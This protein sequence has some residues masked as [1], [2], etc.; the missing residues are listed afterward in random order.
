MRRSATDPEK[1]TQAGEVDEI[2]QNMLTTFR[3]WKVAN[4]VRNALIILI[5]L[6]VL[7]CFIPTDVGGHPRQ[8]F[9]KR[10]IEILTSTL[11]SF[12][13]DTGRFPMSSEGLQALLI[14]PVN[15]PG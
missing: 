1:A 3:R 2:P 4:T 11:V 8:Y 6:F 9:A 7:S 12:Q 10:D 14:Q 15:T 5:G 13:T